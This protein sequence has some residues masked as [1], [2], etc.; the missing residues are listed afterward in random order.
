MKIL[1]VLTSH[2]Q[3]GDTG[4]KTGFWLEELA[5]PYYVFK[6]AGWEITLASPKGG[7]PPLDPK[8][9]EPDFQTEMTRRFEAD[10]EANKALAN[11]VKLADVSSDDFDTVFYPGGHG[12]MW[13]LAESKDS[14]GLLESF[15][16]ASKPIALV[17]HAPAALRH[18]KA[19]DGRLLIEGKK[20][21]G[22][23][24][25]EEAAVG[26]TEVV[27]FLLEDDLKAKGGLYSS[28]PDW[29]PHIVQDGLLI[30]GQNPA[31]STGA[32]Q[33]LI[34]EVKALA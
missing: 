11:T 15:I 26:L 33:R 18:V 28:G 21:A 16:A 12:P 2:D 6:D 30:T 4:R 1:I 17:C 14:A 34:G 10:A 5:A 22:F 9:N 13:D 29:A 8:S 27:P 20:V 25:S 7:Q 32:A 3:L 31:S 23:T 19:P 24:N